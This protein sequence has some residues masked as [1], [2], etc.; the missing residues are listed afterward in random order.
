MR[1]N[2]PFIVELFLIMNVRLSL[3]KVPSTASCSQK[4]YDHYLIFCFSV[5][6]GTSCLLPSLRSFKLHLVLLWRRFNMWRFDFN[7][8]LKRVRV[9][10]HASGLVTKQVQHVL[11]S[12][13]RRFNMW[14]FAL[15]IVWEREARERFLW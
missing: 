9:C 7:I 13:W 11:T 1:L 2:L 12:I 10:A 14:W 5:W 4:A 15:N 6:V 8:A 3:E